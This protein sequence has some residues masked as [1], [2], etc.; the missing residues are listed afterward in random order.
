MM[1]H[2]AASG[3]GRGNSDSRIS[4]PGRR[5]NTLILFL[6]EG[7]CVCYVKRVKELANSDGCLGIKRHLAYNKCSSSR[8]A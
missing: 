3:R 6:N 5:L 7:C 2:S 4:P 8:H 1:R